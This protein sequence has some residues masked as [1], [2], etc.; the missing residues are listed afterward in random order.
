MAIGAL[1]HGMTIPEPL[2]DFV[3]AHALGD[4]QARA[5]VTGSIFVTD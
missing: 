4:K 1:D 2:A 3:E 5:S